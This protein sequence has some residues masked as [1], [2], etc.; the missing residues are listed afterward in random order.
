MSDTLNPHI[1]HTTCPK[2]NGE[3]G[4][5]NTYSPDV[6]EHTRKWKRCEECGGKGWVTDENLELVR[7]RLP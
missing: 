3:G 4:R 6:P 7:W 2:C 5:W 1:G